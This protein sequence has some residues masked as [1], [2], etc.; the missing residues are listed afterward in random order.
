MS[1]QTVLNI[2]GILVM[3]CGASRWAMLLCGMLARCDRVPSADLPPVR[4]RSTPPACLTFLS[5]VQVSSPLSTCSLSAAAEK[6]VLS[7][8]AQS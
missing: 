2:G 3:T 1:V 8:V 7:G 6:N 5:A 4:S